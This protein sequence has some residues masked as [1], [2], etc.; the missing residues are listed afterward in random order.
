MY[1]P[2]TARWTAVDPLAKACV[3]ISPFVYCASNPIIVRDTDG[4]IIETV[5]DVASLA[6]GVKSFVSNVKQGNVGAAI[7]DGIGIIADAAAVATPFVP[8]GVGAGIKA[9]RAGDKVA[10][11]VKDADKASDAAK[12]INKGES[13]SK[14][15]S[16]VKNTTHTDDLKNV[17]YEVPGS[18]TESGKP[19]IGR[20]N[21]FS[22]RQHENR[23]GRDRTKAKIIGHYDPN[24]LK[25]GAIEEQKAINE[26]RKK[27]GDL[28]NKRNEI[29]EKDWSKYGI[30]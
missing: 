1:D 26:A 6:M 13:A 15:G 14:I 7:I 9:I 29:R 23:D 20:T 2:F 18:A 25:S 10:D 22:R 4:N 21:D 30:H 17:I 12:I 19:Y 5:L 24:N 27:Y 11:I 8:G 28:D 16:A 3:P